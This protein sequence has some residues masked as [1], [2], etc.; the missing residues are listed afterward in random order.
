MGKP[1]VPTYDGGSI[2]IVA[3][4]WG[5]LAG[6]DIHWTQLAGLLSILVAIWLIRKDK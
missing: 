6:E 4:F 1:P 5:F 3:L 2:P